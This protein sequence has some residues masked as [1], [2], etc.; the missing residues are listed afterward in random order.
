MRYGYNL[1]TTV[2]FINVTLPTEKTSVK[3]YINDSRNVD[4]KKSPVTWSIDVVE[5]SQIKLP[6]SE[7]NED[8]YLYPK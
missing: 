7:R 3:D 6:L 4:E 8:N 5:D 1:W 2:I